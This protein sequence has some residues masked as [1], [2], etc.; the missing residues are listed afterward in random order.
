MPDAARWRTPAVL[1]DLLIF[2][3]TRLT[4]VAG[5]MVVR[6]CEGRFGITRREWR[7]VVVLA[8]QGPVASSALALHAQLDRARTSRAVSSLVAKG[9]LQRS[10]GRGDRRYA[11]LSLTEE[12]RALHAELFPLVAEI[13]RELMSVLPDPLADAFGEA[14]EC[15]MQQAQAMTA[16]AELPNAGRGRRARRG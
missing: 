16:K 5:S 7:L 15:L 10:I 8:E 1:D 11:T 3:M 2:R 14:L 9:L 13:N 6:L 4:S 12:G